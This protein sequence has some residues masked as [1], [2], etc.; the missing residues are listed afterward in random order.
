MRIGRGL[1]VAASQVWLKRPTARW[2]SEEEI[3][4][5]RA[6]VSLHDDHLASVSGQQAV[7]ALSARRTP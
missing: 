4:V 7:N 6:G 3:A 2:P 1:A 5:I